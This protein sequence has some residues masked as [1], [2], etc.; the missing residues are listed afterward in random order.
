MLENITF[1]KLIYVTKALFSKK[2]I[3]LA[4]FSLVFEIVSSIQTSITRKKIFGFYFVSR[5]KYDAKSEINP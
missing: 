1:H 3:K 5:I 4:I 2:T